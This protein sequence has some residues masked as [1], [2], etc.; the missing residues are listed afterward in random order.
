MNK[1]KCSSIPVVGV[2]A[3]ATAVRAALSHD[4]AATATATAAGWQDMLLH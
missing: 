1:I 3:A 4:A 2:V